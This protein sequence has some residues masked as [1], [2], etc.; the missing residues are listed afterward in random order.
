M[1]MKEDKKQEILDDFRRRN[2][3][4]ASIF[5]TQMQNITQ[6][7][8]EDK[9]LIK[10]YVEKINYLKDDKKLTY[11]QIG[12]SFGLS[13]TIIQKHLPSI[14]KKIKGKNKVRREIK[15]TSID[16]FYLELFSLF[17]QESPMNL[18]G[19]SPNYSRPSILA[20]NYPF[21]AIEKHEIF[22]TRSIIVNLIESEE[23]QNLLFDIIKISDAKIDWMRKIKDSLFS[24]P[25]IKELS[26]KQFI[27][28][29]HLAWNELLEKNQHY[30]PW[31]ILCSSFITNLYKIDFELL[32]TF[33]NISLDNELIN[34][35]HEWLINGGFLSKKKVFYGKCRK[36]MFQS[37]IKLKK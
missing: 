26:E 23:K 24:S 11:E 2:P 33:A 30:R 6:E 15:M 25:K 36:E 27:C 31:F 4:Y 19:L 13:H 14:W 10:S 35:V 28:D 12:N 18:I 29:S 22:L 7:N 17:F 16:P 1:A 37:F 34:S 3:I 8:L 21:G 9:N 32:N 5:K 20:P